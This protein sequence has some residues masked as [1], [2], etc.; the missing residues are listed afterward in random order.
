MNLVKGQ[1]Y[2]LELALIDIRGDFVSGKPVS[3]KVYKSSDNTLITSGSMTEV[4]TSGIYQV[5]VTL[6]EVGQYRVEYITPTKY[7]NVI[8]E[9]FVVEADLSEIHTLVKRILGLSQEN[10]R[11]FNPQYNAKN[12]LTSGKI[13]IY[14][15]AADCNADI[16]PIAEYQI[17]TVY[18]AGKRVSGYRVTK[19]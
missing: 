12:E 17:T 18:E 15:S 3:Y 5:S 1:T 2:K 19:N 16:S 9:I 4:G 10:F 13:R 8:E 7:E 14:N 6:N 11:I